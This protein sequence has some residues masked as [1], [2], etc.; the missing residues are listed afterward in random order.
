MSEFDPKKLHVRIDRKMDKVNTAFRRRY[1]LT[2]SDSTG[3][4]FLTIGSTYNLKQISGFYTRLMRDEILG[5]WKKDNHF[6]LN[7]YCHV[8]GGIVI[9]TAK[10]RNS[11][12]R[13]HMPM[14]LE[15]ICFGDKF[16]LNKNQDFQEAPICVHFSATQKSLDQ[17]EKWGLIK[18]YFLSRK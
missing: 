7:I 12:F 10:W 6:S 17:T 3:D 1:T 13:Y 5:E 16:F 4:L 18:N 14:V 9:G 8:S 15:A 11:I 2:H